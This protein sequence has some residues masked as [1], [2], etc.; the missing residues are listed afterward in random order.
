MKQPNNLQEAIEILMEAQAG[1]LETIKAMPENDFIIDTHHFLGHD[2][3]K[4]WGLWFNDTQ[5]SKW[6][7][8]KEIYHGD[9]RSAIILTSFY[10]T[11]AGLDIDLEGQINEVKLYW[12]EEGFKDG[13]YKSEN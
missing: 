9:D 5:I 13:I 10:R 4:S 1:Q 11:V 8:E 7:C 12:K 2:L 6:F 3:R